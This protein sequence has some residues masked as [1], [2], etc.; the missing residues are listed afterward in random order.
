MGILVAAALCRMVGPCIA[1]PPPSILSL[2]SLGGL[3]LMAGWPLQASVPALR[4]PRGLQQA[5]QITNT[6]RAYS[7]KCLLLAWRLLGDMLFTSAQPISVPG[8]HTLV[9]APARCWDL[10]ELSRF[11]HQI[12]PKTTSPLETVFYLLR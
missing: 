7:H 10:Y 8:S 3:S 6:L 1:E 11:D 2:L 5:L 4:L 9:A 12:F